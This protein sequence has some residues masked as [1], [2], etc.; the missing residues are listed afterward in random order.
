MEHSDFFEYFRSL[1]SEGQNK[2]VGDLA[3]Y[4]NTNENTIYT[5]RQTELEKSG[6]ICPQCKSHDVV[7]YGKYREVKRYR[8]KSCKKTFNSLTGSVASCL[9]KK[10]LLKQYIYFMLKGYSLRKIAS[11]MDIC[12]KTAFDWRHKLLNNLSSDKDNGLSGVVEADET[13]FLYSEKGNKQLKERKSRKRGGKAGKKGI[14]KDHVT[15]LTAYERK[16][17]VFTNT[18]VCRGRITKKAIEKG[19][20]SKLIKDES[21][22]CVDSHKSYQGFAMDNNIDI[23][24]IF[25]RKKQ[26]VIEKI[27]HIQHVNSLHNYLKKWMIK[28][29][30]VATKYL[31]NYMNYFSLVKTIMGSINQAENAMINVLK[32]RNVFVKRDEINQQLCIT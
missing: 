31:Q 24:R 13:F 18:V 8:C 4:L 22:L 12:L 32:G 10:N 7:G 15:V 26:Y 29:N 1:T 20:G 11:S 30:G 17:G 21:I 6:L 14:N 25:V 27:Y 3:Q 9:H 2:I 28:F 23:K 19:L 5:A 16:T